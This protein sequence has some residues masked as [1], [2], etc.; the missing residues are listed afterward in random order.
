MKAIIPFSHQLLS[1]IISDGNTVIDATCGNGND[2]LFL[3]K[4]VGKQGKV[5]GFDIQEAA[6][7]NTTKRIEAE[8]KEN[9]TLIHDGHESMDKYIPADEK[10]AGAIFNL[11]YLPKGDHS[12]VTKPLSTIKAVESIMGRLKIGGRI[13]LVV[14]HGHQGGAEEKNQ[15][16]TYC[17]DLDQQ[18]YQVLQ[19]QFINQK[20]QPPFIVAVEKIKEITF[21]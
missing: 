15:L 21:H 20:N 18:Y 14:Y 13:V 8:S 19:Y 4:L 1:E 11:G 7:E 3:S 10:I 9:V 16:L 5:Y 6:I 12:I 2:T 17:N